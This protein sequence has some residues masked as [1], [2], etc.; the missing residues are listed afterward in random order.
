MAQV[1]ALADA[2]VKSSLDC[3]ADLQDI[4]EFESGK[5]KQWQSIHVCS[6]FICFLTHMTMRKAFAQFGPQRRDRT[7]AEVFHERPVALAL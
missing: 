1:D 2:I 3:A 5:E 7:P 4:I 6:E